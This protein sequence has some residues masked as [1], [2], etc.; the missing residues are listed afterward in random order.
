MEFDSNFFENVKI[1]P[2]Y[3]PIADNQGTIVLSKYWSHEWHESRW[4]STDSKKLNDI[5]KHS[6]HA[7]VQNMQILRNERFEDSITDAKEVSARDH[8]P[9]R[10][11][12]QARKHLA[13]AG[14]NGFSTQVKME[15]FSSEKG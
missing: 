8:I 3:L 13:M 11:L 6:C 12:R 10:S 15:G 7:E 9:S 14:F 4:L 5:I 1:P 2:Y